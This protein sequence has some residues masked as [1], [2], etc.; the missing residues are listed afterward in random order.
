[1]N[2]SVVYELSCPYWTILYLLNYKNKQNRTVLRQ[3]RFL[4]S[5]TCYW[6]P[7]CLLDRYHKTTQAGW[8]STVNK[9]PVKWCTELYIKITKAGCWSVINKPLATW[10]T[11]LNC[12][13]SLSCCSCYY[14]C[15]KFTHELLRDPLKKQKTKK[16][17][18]KKKKIIIIKI[19]K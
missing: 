13:L 6:L 9:P 14:L 16:T 11:E 12:T 4:L 17:K 15:Y 5:C 18:N 3:Q 8:R 2:L 7:R 19:N 1:M 10:W